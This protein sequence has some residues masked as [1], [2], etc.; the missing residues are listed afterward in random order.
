MNRIVHSSP[1][2]LSLSVSN[3][4]APFALSG[5]EREM[6]C[7]EWAWKFL[8]TNQRYRSLYKQ[9][10]LWQKANPNTRTGAAPF[11]D[12]HPYR[13]VYFSENSCRKQFGLSTWLDPNNESLPILEEGESWFSPL[14]SVIAR[15][16]SIK[17]LEAVESLFGFRGHARQNNESIEIGAS[18]SA[19][20]W[21]LID[22]SV[23]IDA[24]I[25]SVKFLCEQYALQVREAKWKSSDFRLLNQPVVER[26]ANNPLLYG[27]DFRI[28]MA[29]SEQLTDDNDAW[30]VLRIDILGQTSHQIKEGR[31]LLLDVRDN[32]LGQG[33]VVRQSFERLWRNLAGSSGRGRKSPTDGDRLKCY[34]LVAEC[35]M[36]GITTPEQIIKTLADNGAGT[37]VPKEIPENWFLWL[38]KEPQEKRFNR[39][40]KDAQAYVDEDYKWLVH[41]QVSSSVD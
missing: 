2:G 10:H 21:F 35:I 17:G 1:I 36:A 26:I 13:T 30:R 31:K 34:V 28:A 11:P 33:L 24:Q 12:E 14:K 38:Q 18:C 32:L 7:E 3:G 27:H 15:P 41:S 40:I 6:G 19:G 5:A 22:C 39:Y 25:S 37:M 9:A 29:G 4:L 8:R 16:E 20:V 23:P